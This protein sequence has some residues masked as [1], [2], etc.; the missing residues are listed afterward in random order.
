MIELVKNVE[1]D[2]VKRLVEL[3]ISAFDDGG[4]NKWHL[5]PLIR[6]GRVFIIRKDQE[7]VGLIQYM[8]DWDCPQRAYMVGVSTDKN[9]RGKGL[10]TR[11]IEE[12]FKSLY[13]E[14]ITEIELT[15]D[16]KNAAAVAIY[17]KK[18]G[19]QIIELRENEYGPGENRLIMKLQLDNFMQKL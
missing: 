15:V 4:L 11:L 16:P 7:V 6:H 17:E 8:L 1:P 10:G 14:D 9:F 12:S 13:R 3:E 18:L 5:V 2:L 19:F